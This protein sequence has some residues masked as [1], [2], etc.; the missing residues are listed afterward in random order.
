MINTTKIKEFL[1]RYE[2]EDIII[3]L[4]HLNDL[5]NATDKTGKPV[6][7]FWLAKRDPEY[8]ANCFIKVAKDWLKFDGKNITLQSTGISYNWVAFKNKMLLVYPESKID[9]PTLV[10]EGDEFSFAKESG[11]VRYTHN[12]LHPF[13]RKETEIIGGYIVIK[14]S[15]WEFLTTMNKEELK[16]H[17][18]T[19]KTQSIW[20][21]WLQEMCL[22]TI[23][24]KG[25]SAHFRDIFENMLESDNEEYDPTVTTAEQRNYI[26]EINKI[27]SIEE[28][29]AYYKANEWLGKEFVAE[30][31]R[32]KNELSNQSK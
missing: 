16:K 4:S 26:E 8:F 13:S 10:Y 25:F 29:K 32:R 24:K 23:A 20:N 30:V 14:N 1:T 15:R 12:I 21:Q 28:L 17:Q 2:Q 19:A 5:W 31:T 7:Q 9:W 27:T 6:N 3:Y 11:S 18:A 22:K